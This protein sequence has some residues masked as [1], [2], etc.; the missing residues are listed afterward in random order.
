MVRTVLALLLV[1][2]LAPTLGAD[3]ALAGY[4]ASQGCRAAGVPADVPDC[5][6]TQEGEAALV[7][8]DATTCTLLVSVASQASGLLPGEQAIESAIVAD[9][10][11]PLCGTVAVSPFIGSVACGGEAE[12][13]FAVPG[14]CRLLLVTTTGTADKVVKAA[15]F[16]EIRV[17][18]DGTVTTA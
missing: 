11:T 5:R 17:C 8:C 18:R 4:G 15:A 10:T 9:E 14:A 16:S 12:V 7:G 13:T 3:A 6:A 1:S 2:L